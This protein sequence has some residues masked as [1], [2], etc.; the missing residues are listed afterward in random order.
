MRAGEGISFEEK[1]SADAEGRLNMLI[2]ERLSDPVL[3]AR[4]VRIE[5]TRTEHA[6]RFVIEDQGKG[7]NV[8][9]LRDPRKDENLL[10]EGGRGILVARQAADRVRYNAKGNQVTLVKRFLAASG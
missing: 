6:V 8:K 1:Q 7:F 4:R 10:D 5:R 9:K 2:A 3:A